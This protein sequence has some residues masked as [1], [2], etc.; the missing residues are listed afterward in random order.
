VLLLYL[1]SY[2]LGPSFAT[3]PHPAASSISKSKQSLES[4]AAKDYQMLGGRDPRIGREAAVYV[5]QMKGYRGRLIEIG[6][7]SGKIECPGR[8]LPTYTALLKHLVLM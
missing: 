5:G 6:R 3:T 7:N 1:E 8:Q 2:A 4:E